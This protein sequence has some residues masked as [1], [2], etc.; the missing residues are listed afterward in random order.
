MERP[1]RDG[2]ADRRRRD[3]RSLAYGDA[4][5]RFLNPE[6]RVVSPAGAY[7]PLQDVVDGIETRFADA[8][9]STVTLPSRADGAL[10]A[11]LAA[12]PPS[13]GGTGDSPR[14][15]EVFVDPYTGGLLGQ[16]RAGRILLERQYVIPLVVRLH[17][18]LL[19]G[20]TGVWIMGGVS[21]VWLATSVLG[22]VLAWPAAARRAAAWIGTVRVRGRAGLPEVQL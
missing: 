4:I 12:K 21:I 19:L 7:A 1:G 13:M 10:I 11:Y 20:S 3:R 9:V 14:F 22:V 2:A 5:D 17:Y 8:R 18:A 16:R 15:S 6:I